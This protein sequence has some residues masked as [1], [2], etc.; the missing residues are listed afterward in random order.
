MPATCPYRSE[1]SHGLVTDVCIKRKIRN[2]V[3]RE[4]WEEGY[5]IYVRKGGLEL[6][7]SQG[8]RCAGNPAGRKAAQRARRGCKLTAFMSPLL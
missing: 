4:R 7:A 2:Y 6:T 3:D 1:T 5:D 8:V